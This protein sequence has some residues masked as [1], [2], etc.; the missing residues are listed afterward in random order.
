MQQV[1]PFTTQVPIV[2]E[3]AFIL[4]ISV[5]NCFFQLLK[6]FIRLS[7]VVFRIVDSVEPLRFFIQCLFLIFD[8]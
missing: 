6:L 5:F 4:K 2:D 7:S 1:A 8:E 3:L